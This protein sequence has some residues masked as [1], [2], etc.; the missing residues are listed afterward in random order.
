MREVHSV[1]SLSEADIV[2]SLLDANGVK[3]ILQDE[4]IAT[5][6]PAVTFYSGIKV[7][8]N[9]EDYDLAKEILEDYLQEQVDS[10]GSDGQDQ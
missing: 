5:S 9:D 3:C 10:E 2:K 7:L 6:Y 1:S 8:V 4:N